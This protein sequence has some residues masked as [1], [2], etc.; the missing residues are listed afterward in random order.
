M[1][2]YFGIP[3]VLNQFSVDF[4]HDFLFRKWLRGE[5]V[6][7]LT[8]QRWMPRKYLIFVSIVVT[9]LS[10]CIRS[11]SLLPCSLKFS[12]GVLL[13]ADWAWRHWKLR[14]VVVWTVAAHAVVQQ[15]GFVDVG[16]GFWQFF[17]VTHSLFDVGI[18]WRPADRLSW[19]HVFCAEHFQLSDVH[20]DVHVKDCSEEFGASIGALLLDC[21]CYTLFCGHFKRV[22]STS[23][24]WTGEKVVVTARTHFFVVFSSYNMRSGTSLLVFYGSRLFFLK[25]V[26]HFRGHCGGCGFLVLVGSLNISQWLIVTVIKPFFRLIFNLIFFEHGGIKL[27]VILG[28]C[29]DSDFLAL[30]LFWRRGF[31]LFFVDKDGFKFL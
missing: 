1:F 16:V 15:L 22:A 29:E 13:F 27:V 10:L 24:Q 6:V 17:F 18:C 21:T 5:D 19:V 4:L 30:F 9:M 2:L 23:A 28:F 25:S 20:V 7:F 3:W 14:V 8:N 11:G 31:S 26:H 12:F